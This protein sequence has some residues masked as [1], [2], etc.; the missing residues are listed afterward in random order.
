[1]IDVVG[2]QYVEACPGGGKTWVIMGR[3]ARRVREERR[4]GVALLSFT[5]AAIGEIGD[6]ARNAPELMRSPNFV[7]TFDSFLHRFI[8]TPGWIVTEGTRPRYCESWAQLDL[9]EV[10]IRQHYLRLDEVRVDRDFKMSIGWSSIPPQRLSGVRQ[11]QTVL[12]QRASKLM[13]SLVRGGMISCEFAR[14]LAVNYIGVDE[15]VRRIA[16]RFAEIIVDEG[17]DCG[18][19]EI[20]VLRRLRDADVKVFFMEDPNQA[21]FEFRRSTPAIVSE[22]TRALPSGSR[23]SGNR[24][25]SQAVCDIARS[26]AGLV[27]ADEPI[28]RYAAATE[29]IDV[30][31]GNNAG[32][33]RLVFED[34][35]ASRNQSRSDAIVLAH[36]TKRAHQ[37]AGRI[38]RTSGTVS[39]LYAL[40]NAVEVLRAEPLPKDRK[41]A[42]ENIERAVVSCFGFDLG[43]NTI[44]SAC[45]AGVIDARWL[46]RSAYWLSQAVRLPSAASAKDFQTDVVNAIEALECPSGVQLQS[47][48]QRL[49][50]PDAAVWSTLPVVDD[51]PKLRAAT[52]HSVKGMEF[53]AVLLA[54]EER[55]QKT[56]GLTVID[57][58]E[59]GVDHEPLRVLYVGAT[60]AERTL[61]LAV[62][63]SQAAKVIG[64]L[65]RDQVPFRRIDS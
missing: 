24:R 41:A 7:G 59:Q 20:V 34:I 63:K 58:W 44:R 29:P 30:I 10:R 36:R 3:Y 37:V 46:R 45:E 42:I 33:I 21:I 52:I 43:D 28:G 11:Y 57:A 18:E 5:N 2:D 17:Q 12:L 62:T 25:S 13:M 64:I 51:V 1:M 56:N 6:R 15:I 61:A 47:V 32:S 26:L 50:V 54:L 9:P 53:E 35:L 65:G 55:L 31:V 48:R 19:E 4:K 8:V 22:F 49:R 60:R 27:T 39:R 23:L 14:Q 16:G 38:I 40:A